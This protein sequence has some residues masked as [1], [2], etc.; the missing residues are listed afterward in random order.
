MI[1][2]DHGQVHFAE[3]IEL[4]PVAPLVAAYSG[5]ARFRYLHARARQAPPPARRRPRRRSA[6]VAWVFSRDQLIDEGWLGPRA[7]A[8]RLPDADRRR[9]PGRQGPGRLRRP[10]PP[11]GDPP[12]SRPR[13]PHAEEM[14]VPLLAGRGR[15]EPA[16]ASG[17]STLV[18]A[19]P[20]P[21]SVCL[22]RLTCR[23]TTHVE[24]ERPGG[25]AGL[26]RSRPARPPAV[27]RR[28]DAGMPPPCCTGRRHA[29]AGIASPRR[30]PVLPP[31]IA[32]P[33]LQDLRGRD[34][35]AISSG[36]VPGEPATSD[37]SIWS[38]AGSAPGAATAW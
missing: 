19:A 29:A 13:Q 3:W 10:H 20:R 24:S 32:P 36:S 25:I 33:G 4:D 30:S 38:A 22:A 34:G 35:K 26:R 1:T 12:G 2:A 5:D 37:A 21:S 8:G 15:A 18:V 6:S 23:V 11:H 17:P 28:A 16:V 9:R 27:G 14:L 7:A 31:H